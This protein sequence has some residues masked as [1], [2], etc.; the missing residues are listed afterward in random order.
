M[1]QKTNQITSGL[2]D[3]IEVIGNY[4]EEHDSIRPIDIANTLKV[5]RASVSEALRRL[6]E[7]ELINYGRYGVITI[8]EK[9][10]NAAQNVIKRHNTFY[11]FLHE[12]LKMP[13]NIASENACKIEH[14]VSEELVERLDNFLNYCSTSPNFV[15]NYNKYIELENENI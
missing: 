14:V 9:G 10:K 7:I 3:Y 15:S 12:I 6:S 5:S 8:T 11:K 1:T 2:E 4:L 13:K